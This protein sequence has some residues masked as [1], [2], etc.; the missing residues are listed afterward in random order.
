MARATDA[1]RRN[2][3]LAKQ[4]AIEEEL[5]KLDARQSDQE[6]K[7]DTRRKVIAGALALEDMTKNPNGPLA[8]RLKELLEDFVEPRSRHLFP[9]IKQLGVKEQAKLAAKDATASAPKAA[10]ID[11][12]SAPTRPGAPPA[13]GPEGYRPPEFP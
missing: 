12:P 9:F 6:R 13:P 10:G 4:K 11:A 5:K 8:A 1:D 7:D 3:L 2:A